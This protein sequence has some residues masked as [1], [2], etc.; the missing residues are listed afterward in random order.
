MKSYSLKSLLVILLI[1]TSQ[2]CV[3][4]EN[5]GVWPAN[6]SETRTLDLAPFSTIKAKDAIHVAIT[7]GAVQDVVITGNREILNNVSL[8][9]DN[10]R[11][12]VEL[13]NR[14]FLTPSHVTLNVII[15][16]VKSVEFSGA[17]DG[18]ISN[19]DNLEE[20]FVKL[21]GASD[22][23]I[24]GTAQAI[25]FDLSGA[26]DLE[27]M[28]NGMY[29]DGKLSGAS[30]LNASSYQV[31]ESNLNLSGASDAKVR[32]SDKIYVNASGASVVWC[33]GTAEATTELSGG[34]S[35]RRK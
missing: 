32:V 16:I 4:I 8:T 11:L 28:G 6:N 12:N 26:S 18:S 3:Y 7:Y 2:A 27:I 5:D 31:K 22:L 20:L 21:S 34:S 10:D 35:F 17:V 9:V 29:L 14:W 33:S 15:P 25:K 19:F 24:Q 1:Y 23:N 30:E 13:K